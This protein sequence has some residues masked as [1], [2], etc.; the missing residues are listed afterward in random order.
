MASWSNRSCYRAK[1]AEGKVSHRFFKGLREAYD[2][3]VRPLRQLPPGCEDHTDRPWLGE[4]ACGC[5]GAGAPCP[6]CKAVEVVAL[7]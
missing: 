3:V 6:I 5:W 4:R 2:A 1:S 7:P